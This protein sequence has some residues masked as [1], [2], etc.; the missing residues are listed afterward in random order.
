MKTK[1]SGGRGAPLAKFAKD[2]TIATTTTTTTTTTDCGDDDD[3]VEGKI[4]TRV[5]EYFNCF[6][7]L[8]RVAARAVRATKLA[9]RHKS[10]KRVWSAKRER[11]RAP[12]QQTPDDRREHAL[13]CVLF[14]FGI[15]VAP[16]VLLAFI[17]A[18]VA[19]HTE[20]TRG[21]PNAIA[22]VLI[23]PRFVF[24]FKFRYSI[25]FVEFPFHFICLLNS[26]RCFPPPPSLEE[27]KT[28]T[29]TKTKFVK[30]SNDKLI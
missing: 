21:A 27:S 9:R 29:T 23:S 16:R 3:D 15:F 30:G 10:G 12:S 1:N 19:P 6:E 24:F 17:A 18:A 26:N 5:A 25:R 14:F 20:K 4:F 28:P 8:L 11:Q 7:L 13:H 2:E 22:I